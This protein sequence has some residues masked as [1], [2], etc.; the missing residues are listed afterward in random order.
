MAKIEKKVSVSNNIAVDGKFV[1][2]GK[3]VANFINLRQGETDQAA[4]SFI[5]PI[6]QFNQ[7]LMVEAR[8]PNVLSLSTLYKFDAFII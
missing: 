7:P 5:K 4:Y 2:S 6:I 3:K 1:F 8:R